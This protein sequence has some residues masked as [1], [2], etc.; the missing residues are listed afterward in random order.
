MHEKK[1]DLRLYNMK[2]KRDF[3]THRRNMMALAEGRF[4]SLQ[5]L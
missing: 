2:K 1:R 4:L 3:F 5:R